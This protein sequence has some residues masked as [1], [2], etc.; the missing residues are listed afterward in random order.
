MYSAPIWA[1]KVT[2]TPTSF[3]GKCVAG[4]LFVPGA[5]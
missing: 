5:G 2:D 1:M 3:D 4:E